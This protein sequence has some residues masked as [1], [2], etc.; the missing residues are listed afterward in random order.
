MSLSGGGHVSDCGAKV[1]KTNRVPKSEP[2]SH[3]EAVPL[4]GGNARQAIPGCPTCWA[5]DTIR[6]GGQK[7]TAALRMRGRRC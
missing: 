2:W 6:E 7:G 4:E 5:K 1:I 3:L